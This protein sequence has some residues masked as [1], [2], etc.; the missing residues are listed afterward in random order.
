M[1]YNGIDGVWSIAVTQFTSVL[2][3]CI[4]LTFRAVFFDLE[5]I[6]SDNDK[7]VGAI[8]SSGDHNQN[9]DENEK[10]KNLEEGEN[11]VTADQ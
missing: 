8:S 11:E 7:V 3:A 2:M 6:E 1:C 10:K 4:I 5:I 9:N